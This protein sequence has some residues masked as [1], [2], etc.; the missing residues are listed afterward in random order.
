MGALL[1]LVLLA[2]VP[3]LL[4]GALVY[5]LTDRGGDNVAAGIVDGL[6]R[7]GPSNDST[8]VVSYRGRLPPEFDRSFPIY[9]GADV[10]VSIAMASQDGTSYFIVLSSDDSASDVFS[11]Y[12]R[13]LDADPWQVEIG[14][15]SDEFTG[16]RFGRPDNIDVSGD[17]TIH[18][19]DLDGRTVV[20][21]SYQDSSLSL[22][23]GA[24]R[25]PPSIGSSKP[26]PPGF[27]SDLPIYDGAIIVDTYFERRQGGQAFIVSFLTRDGQSDILDFYTDEFRERGWVVSPSSLQATGFA[28][29]LDFDDGT[30]RTISGSITA[31]SYRADSSYTRVDLLVQVSPGRRGN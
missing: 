30:N 2:V 16:L 28:R 29:G 13:R 15:S 18:H 27:P 3:A 7:L 22:S 8:N 14:R 31:D 9:G 24:T 6:L 20:Y 12:S 21:L 5:S 10:I 4:V 23:P 1:P 26:L 19:S 25:T 17:V 11:F